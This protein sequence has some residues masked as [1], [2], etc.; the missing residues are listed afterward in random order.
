MKSLIILNYQMAFKRSKRHENTHKTCSLDE[1]R[2]G[3]LKKYILKA[4]LWIRNISWRKI[5]SSDWAKIGTDSFKRMQIQFWRHINYA[6]EVVT[7]M[8]S[9][10]VLTVCRLAPS[11]TSHCV[12]IPTSSR[13]S[14]WASSDDKASI[15]YRGYGVV[16]IRILM[17]CAFTYLI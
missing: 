1:N 4:G 2:Y 5:S 12:S 8:P 7:T 13:H 17:R 9:A 16:E 11:L 3:A 10:P 15:T 6:R 14:R